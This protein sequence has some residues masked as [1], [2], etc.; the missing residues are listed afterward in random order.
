M[1][2]APRLLKKFC[3]ISYVQKR[4]FPGQSD[5]VNKVPVQS[6]KFT[7]SDSD[8]ADYFI[9]KVQKIGMGTDRRLSRYCCPVSLEFE[10]VDGDSKEKTMTRRR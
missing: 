6:A 10:V 1:N 2:P 3:L 5:V 9:F 7:R 8:K 4:N